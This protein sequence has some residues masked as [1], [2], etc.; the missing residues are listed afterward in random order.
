MARLL[1]AALLLAQSGPPC[2]NCG[3]PKKPGA[4][5]SCKFDPKTARR[6]YFVGTLAKT[7]AGGFEVSDGFIQASLSAPE[8]RLASL[9]SLVDKRVRIQA[10]SKGDAWLVERL[11]EAAPRETD[12]VLRGKV[13]N[14][15]KAL[16][17]RAGLLQEGRADPLFVTDVEN[18]EYVVRAARAKAGGKESYSVV[19]WDDKDRD[20]LPNEGARVLTPAFK[21]RD[22]KWFN[23][24]NELVES[25]ASVELELPN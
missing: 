10:L 7:E 11:D 5:P 19:V 14:A 8:S 20:G 17:L 4:C 12:L 23:P 21:F 1:L 13:K 15:D 22:G 25:P 2:V 6:G 9:R 18:R 3:K 16:C 24:A